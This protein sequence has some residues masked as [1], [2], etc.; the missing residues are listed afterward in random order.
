M[1]LLP[2]GTRWRETR[3]TFRRFFNQFASKRYAATQTREVRALLK[4]AVTFTHGIDQA[5]LQLYVDAHTM[6]FRSVD[7]H[8]FRTFAA[9]IFD[10]MYGVRIQNK[11]DRYV[12]LGDNAVQGLSLTRIPGRFWI[13]YLPLL[14][15][16]PAWVPGSS[17]RKHGARVRPLAQAT[18]NEAFD[19]VL[20]SMVSQTS[21]SDRFEWTHA[22]TSL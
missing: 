22:C 9:I 10:I 6:Q 11:E 1:G 2:Y 15:Y 8:N 7:S 18:R 5:S 3:R 13:E 4:R 20:A 21:P 16:I 14:K 19:E 12:K 17:A